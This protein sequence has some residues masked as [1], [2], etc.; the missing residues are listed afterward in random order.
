[1]TTR[2]LQRY[3]GFRER[4]DRRMYLT[5]GAS[6][7]LA[8]YAVD[9]GVVWLVTRQVWTPL[10]YLSPL[11][12]LRSEKVA[13][14]PAWLAVA[15]VAWSLPFV[16]IGVSMTLRRAVDAGHSPWL[17]LL[18]FAPVANYALM[19]WLAAAPGRP[20]VVWAMHPAPDTVADRFRSA[21]LAVAVSIGVGVAAVALNALALESYGLSLFLATPFVLGLLSAY[22]HNHGH[23]RT[24]RETR[25]VVL[26][27][28]FLV[29]GSLILFAL[30]GAVCLVMAFPICAV[31]GLLGGAVGRAVA[32][33]GRVRPA[34]TA[35]SLLLL[36]MAAVGD[37]AAPPPPV[38]EA[39]TSIVVEA[40]PERVWENVIRFREIEARP[41]L[42][43]RLGVAYPVRAR[44]VGS[45]VGA[46]R[47]CEFSTG[48][49]VEPITAWEAPRRL[50]FD[51]T[52]QPP[53]LEEWSPYRTVY[54]PHVRGFFRSVRGEFRL[55]E[56]PGGRTRLEGS[57]WY[58]LDIHPQAYWRPIAEWLL[59]R[60]HARVLQQVERESEAAVNG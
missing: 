24:R 52:E 35:Y 21:L 4:V 33:H 23:P 2:A 8:K 58:T 41:G 14:F 22:I 30:E 31:V 25:S 60:I 11:M 39:V 15:L 37:R 13:A 9:A 7:M 49:F 53:A 29:G 46:V 38:Y 48:A 27:S 50:A 54:A 56:L 42:P 5:T 32:V 45:G 59:H 28:L 47:H 44:I 17:A 40:P 1:V 20:G 51:V 18:F 57:T 6:L 19:L 26:L 43:F 16:W 12:S 55:V 34:S 3:F 10:D 36:P